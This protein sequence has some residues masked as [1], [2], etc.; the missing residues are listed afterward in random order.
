MT[1]PENTAL[2]IELTTS[3][4]KAIDSP[5]RIKI[6]LLLAER[7]HVVHEI[8]DKLGYSQPLISQN[9]RTLK[10]LRLVAKVRRGRESLYS[11]PRTDIIDAI[12]ALGKIAVNTLPA[13]PEKSAS[14]KKEKKPRKD[15]PSAEAQS[16]ADTEP[17]PQ[18]PTYLSSAIPFEEFEKRRD[19]ERD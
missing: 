5:I 18:R 15:T 11:L 4:I 6:L 16:S 17:S 13:E 2:D 14:P 19:K 12:Y 9:L 7:N 1:T 10:S 8:V 3:L